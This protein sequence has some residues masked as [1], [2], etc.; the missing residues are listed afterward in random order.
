MKAM[1][2]IVVLCSFKILKLIRVSQR[3]VV[4]D[5]DSMSSRAH[6]RNIKIVEFL[7]LATGA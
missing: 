4:N 7:I 6:S 5:R 1:V 3:K 2:D